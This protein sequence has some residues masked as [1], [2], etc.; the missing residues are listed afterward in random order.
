MLDDIH[1]VIPYIIL[2]YPWYTKYNVG[3]V[4]DWLRARVMWSAGL[5]QVGSYNLTLW[6]NTTIFGRCLDE[7]STVWHEDM[8]GSASLRQPPIPAPYAS[9]SGQA[10]QVDVVAPVHL[11]RDNRG[12][13]IQ[14]Q[15]WFMLQW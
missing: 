15:D 10:E 11:S 7:Y 2:L 13:L 8:H 12:G 1:Y 4:C 9:P 6:A 3:S 14:S 5:G